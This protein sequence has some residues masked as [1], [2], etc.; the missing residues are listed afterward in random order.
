LYSASGAADKLVR[1]FPAAAAEFEKANVKYLFSS[2][3]W[4]YTL[5]SK[6]PVK[7]LEDIK[8]LRVRTFG[9]LSR[10]WAEL[11][12]V[13]VSIPIPEIYDALQKGTLD[14]V[15][16]Q[17]ISMYKSLRLCEVAKHF[18]RIE[19]G[20]LPV[21]VLMNMGTWSKLPEKVRK[22]MVNLESDMPKMV[23]QIISGQELKTIE[24]M[25][26]EGISIYDLPAADKPRIR[27]VAK[28]IAKIVVDDLAAKGVTNAKEAMDIYLSAIEK[29]SK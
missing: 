6:K 14:A 27:E 13:P 22:E 9:Y 21:P 4:H 11:G 26:K 2:G 20:C 24:E 8:G 12:G 7:S 19:L 17:P 10:A 3:V 28:V 1:T 29:Y 15:L 5:I 25:R 16:T 23:D 18:T